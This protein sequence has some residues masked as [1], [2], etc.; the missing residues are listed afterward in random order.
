M[1]DASDQLVILDA[2]DRERGASTIGMIQ[3]N[4]VQ[5]LRDEVV[6][7]RED[8]ARARRVLDA[9]IG[10]EVI[11]RAQQKARAEALEE[12]AQVCSKL[13]DDYEGAAYTI[14]CGDCATAIHALK[15]KRDEAATGQ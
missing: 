15:D 3:A 7:L 2:I 10:D 11:A 6:A 5:R 9:Q 4:Q 1:S 12:A 14:A 8:M 13:D